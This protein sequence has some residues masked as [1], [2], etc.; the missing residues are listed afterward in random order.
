MVTWSQGV[1]LALDPCVPVQWSLKEPL[2]NEL[3]LF[4]IKKKKNNAPESTG[5]LVCR[6][7]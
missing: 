7:C 2:Q 3:K 5:L 4:L 1:G 6:S